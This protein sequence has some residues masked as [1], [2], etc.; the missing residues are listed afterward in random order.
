MQIQGKLVPT[1]NYKVTNSSDH[2]WFDYIVIGDFHV[3]HKMF[4]DSDARK[5]VAWI[6]NRDPKNTAVFVT[7]DMT[8]NI[9]P[10]SKGSPF[11]LAI[12]DP[13]DQ[14]RTAAEILSPIKH[15]IVG[16]CEGNHSYRSVLATGHSPDKEIFELLGIEDRF[17][18][19]SG[20]HRINIASTKGKKPITYT[21][22]AEHGSKNS[23]TIEGKVKLLRS[24]MP[25][26]QAAD[27]YVMGHI[28]TKLAISDRVIRINGNREE[29][30]KVMFASNGSYLFDPEYARRGGFIHGGPGVAKVQ[31]STRRRD[32]HCSI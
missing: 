29:V 22:W 3:G 6:A 14:I 16:G 2:D 24:M 19:Y 18:G 30:V 15:L 21:I 4:L 9:L 13:I 25:A 32:L 28:H 1:Y 5:M 7:G 10:T 17:L 27:L 12:P 26:H 8:E 11:E 23:A 20:Y 31:L